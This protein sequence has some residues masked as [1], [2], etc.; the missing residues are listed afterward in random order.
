MKNTILQIISI[1]FFAQIILLVPVSK[2]S[3]PASFP[4]KSLPGVSIGVKLPSKYEPS[5]IAW[6]LR[7][8]KLFLVSDGGTVSSMNA[9]GKDVTNWSVDS[10]LEAV[11]IPQ[12]R[13][14]FIYLGIEHPDS[15]CEFNIVTGKV[16]RTFDLTKWMNGP[17]KSGLE[18]L[19][20]AGDPKDPEG[21]L[22]YAGL[23]ADGRIFAFRLPILSSKTST[24]V[25]HVRTIA[26]IKAVADISGMQYSPA[27]GVIYAVYDSA[28]LLRAIRPDGKLLKEWR[29][30]GDNQE[31]ITFKDAELYIAHDS[32]QVYRY[33]P[34]TGIDLPSP[35]KFDSMSWYHSHDADRLN[36][37]AGGQLIWQPGKPHQL[38]VNL[39]G[40]TLANVGDSVKAAYL[41]K[42]R[43]KKLGCD[44]HDNIS[45]SGDCDFDADV[46][47]MA[48]TG[49]F[50]I[51]LFDSS[52]KGRVTGDGYGEK[53]DIFKGYLGYQWRF[54][55][56][57]CDSERFWENKADGSRESHTNVTCWKRN[58]PFID[59][60]SAELL[61][62]CDPRSWIRI[63]APQAACLDL[64]FDEW[65][66]LAF[67]IERVTN[68]LKTTFSFNGHSFST[69]DSE[70]SYQPGRID[71]LAIQFP[72]GRPYDYVLLD[73]VGS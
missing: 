48:G 66:L 27:H 42:S 73:K 51:G 49:D 45:G 36:L 71:T 18:A 25:K 8:H 23:Q 2:A 9:D 10:D 39:A 12:P 50:R 59:P 61:G 38:T 37:T 63:R 30:P 13:S 17:K 62:D 24:S 1:I 68:G 46:T 40:Q 6:H 55:P 60:C 7:L 5:G 54:H 28:D 43:G 31:G 47:C 53:N 26:P 21:G 58:Q 19:T 72:N 29:L 15:I 35:L 69:T 65:G 22:F 32:G 52:G 64:G 70:N 20:F 16:T 3:A 14:N 34:F 11:T 4:A 67:T 41:W 33:S 56:H 44:C 57:I